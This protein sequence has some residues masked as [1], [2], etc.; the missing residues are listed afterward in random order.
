MR[1]IWHSIE[2][3]GPGC[4]NGELKSPAKPIGTMW[5]ALSLLI[6]LLAIPTPTLALPDASTSDLSDHLPIPKRPLVW[7]DVNFIHTTDIH[8]EP[9]EGK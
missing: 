8:G 3:Y 7:G 2:H 9:I 5:S 6:P 1:C 4:S